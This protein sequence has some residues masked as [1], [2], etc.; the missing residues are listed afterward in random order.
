MSHVSEFETWYAS[1]RSEM[2][3]DEVMG[4]FL[5]LR[6]ISQHE[7]PVSYVGG[8]KLG[9]TGGTYRFAGNRVQIPDLLIGVDAASAC[10][11]HL[12]KISRLLQN[13]RSAFP[14]RSCIFDALTLEGMNVLGFSL[15]DV[16]VLLGLPPNYLDVDGSFLMEEKLRLLRREFEPVDWASVDRIAAGEFFDRDGVNM[17]FFSGSGDDLVDDMAKLIEL[18]AHHRYKTR[19]VFLTAIANR[20]SSIENDE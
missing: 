8:G 13:F 1:R 4:F 2:K 19:D 14:Y 3:A 17:R 11:D 6:N 15:N 9:R 18:D 7:G 16:G 10:A 12:S 20:I 5:E